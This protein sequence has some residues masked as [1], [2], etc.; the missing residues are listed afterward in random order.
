MDIFL[1]NSTSKVVVA[2]PAGVRYCYAIR[3]NLCITFYY[4]YTVFCIPI[5]VFYLGTE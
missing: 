3:Y 5:A 2:F 4:S 1:E